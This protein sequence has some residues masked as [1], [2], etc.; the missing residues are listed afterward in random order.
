MNAKK[1]HMYTETHTYARSEERSSCTKMES[2]DRLKNPNQF[3]THSLDGTCMFCS[4]FFLRSGFW[5]FQTKSNSSSSNKSDWI[6]LWAIALYFKFVFSVGALLII[7]SKRN[8]IE[9]AIWT[10]I[11]NL[12]NGKFPFEKGSTKVTKPKRQKKCQ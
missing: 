1:T 3:K 10:K 4:W 7:D 5:L 12:S 6:E 2:N 11:M 8:M 9:N